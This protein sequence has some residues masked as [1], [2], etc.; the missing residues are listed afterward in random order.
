ME[1]PGI[2]FVLGCFLLSGVTLSIG[3]EGSPWEILDSEATSLYKNGDY[4]RAVELEKKALESAEKEVA[5]DKSSVATI[6]NNLGAFYVAHGQYAEGRGC[7]PARTRNPRGA[8]WPGSHLSSPKAE[9]L[10]KHSLAIEE[11]VLGPD[12]Q[13]VAIALNNLAELY[14]AQDD[15]TQAEP[16]YKR[17][18]EIQE[19]AFGPR[20]PAARP[21]LG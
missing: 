2:A 7:L 17:S 21:H 14:R 20:R 9:H 12:N 16:L 8:A 1:K 18:L 6:L 5:P 4:E 3:A 13:E 10:H 15:Y 11:K 19:K